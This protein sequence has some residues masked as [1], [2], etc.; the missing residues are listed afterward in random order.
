MAMGRTAM[1]AMHRR[2]NRSH[3]RHHLQQQVLVRMHKVGAQPKLQPPMER[4]SPIRPLAQEAKVGR[5]HQKHD[6]HSHEGLAVRGPDAVDLK[7]PQLQRADQ[8]NRKI[9]V[10]K[11]INQSFSAVRFVVVHAQ[12]RLLGRVSSPLLKPHQAMMPA[13]NKN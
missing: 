2:N 1:A 11:P 8:L 7:T 6:L 4:L 13:Q 10:L 5:R 9:L 12:H 3:P